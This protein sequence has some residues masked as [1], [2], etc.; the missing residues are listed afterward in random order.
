MS[1][2]LADLVDP[3]QLQS[4]AEAL[5]RISGIPIGIIGVDGRVLVA[6][7]WQ[8]VCANYHRVHPACL[9]RCLASDRYIVKTI[10]TLPPDGYIEYKC[11]NGMWDL[12]IPI[13]VDGHHLATC[14][15]GQFFY[16]HEPIDLA[17]FREQAGQHGF[18]P[19]A[20][21]AALEK[22]PVFSKEKVQGIIAYNRQLVSMIS[23]LG[24]SHL[25]Q[26]ERASRLETMHAQLLIE[27]GQRIAAEEARD[28]FFNLSPDLFAILSQ[29]G[30]LLNF[31]AALCEALG[32][33][34]EDLAEMPLD[35]RMHPEDREAALQ[36]IQRVFSGGEPGV[37]TLR[38][39]DRNGNPLWTEWTGVVDGQSLHVAGRD[40]TEQ[41]RQQESMA[42]EIEARKRAEADLLAARD[43]LRLQ[44]ACINRIQ[45]L[46]IGES[47]PDELFETLLFEILTLTASDYGFIVEVRRETS[48]EVNL[49]C[50]SVLTRDGE[51]VLRSGEGG[52]ASSWCVVGDH[53][54]FARLIDM[55]QPLFVNEVDASLALCGLPQGHP[56][57]RAMLGMPIKRGGEILAVLGLA[58]RPAGY[59]AGMIDYL[60]PVVAASAR[61][62]E[63]FG[64]RRRRLETETLLRK[65]EELLRATFESTRSGIL[66]V[67]RHGCILRTNARFREMWRIPADLLTDG[68]DDVLL[69][70]VLRQLKEPDRFL[71]RVKA[72]YETD[73]IDVDL[74]SFVDGR[75]FERYSEPL[76]GEGEPRG[77]VWIFTDITERMRAE[78]AVAENERRLREIASTLAEGL[79]T[80]GRDWR[81]TFINPTALRILGWREEEVLGHS[82]HLLFHHSYPDG[83]MYLASDCYIAQ[84]MKGT[85]V[86]TDTDWLWRK[87]GTCFPVALIASPIERDGVIQGAVVA[88]RD[89]TERK[90]ADEEL[91][92]AK[93]QA[94]QA[95]RVKGDF[96]AAMSHEIRTPMNVVLGMSEL[97]LETSLDVNQRRYAETMHY[98]GKALLGVLNDVLDFSRIEAGRFSLLDLPFSPVRV[99][100]ETARLMRVAAR[101]KG[102][103]L[104]ETI[105]VDLPEL[106]LGD[107]GRVRQV[108]LNLLSNAIKFTHQGRVDV[109]LSWYDQGQDALLFQVADTGIGISEEQARNVFEQFTQADAWITRRYGGTG[110]G[111]AICRRLVELMA[112]RIWV[113]SRL[114]EGSLFRFVLPVRRVMKRDA[115]ASGE[116]VSVAPVEERPLR[117]L[118]AEDVEENRELMAAYLAKTPHRLTMVEDGEEAVR[119]VRAEPFDVVVMDVQMPG[120]DGYTAT[121]LIRSWEAEQ[122]RSPLPVIALSAHAMEGEMER[123]R[124]A[125]C[126]LYLSKPIR[127]KVLIDALRGIGSRAGGQA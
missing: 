109:G 124:E 30:R 36:E 34:R 23:E 60:E 18:D 83:T 80:V 84:V 8:E 9:E 3:R 2:N 44:I 75:L 110:L 79:Y 33:S 49:T 54:L 29:D 61:I 20:Y 115:T 68:R 26:R 102:L 101:E 96:L 64:N 86:N 38:L 94:E 91:R 6:T 87:D 93:E 76:S 45:G 37:F 119:Q 11:L 99:V 122:G 88:F 48:G 47:D 103:V 92:L 95:A 81:I 98:S 21:L 39:I 104:G 52:V 120:M 118:L 57:I 66:V 27:I 113:E 56:P 82:S 106:V 74:L 14:F 32:Y 46:F 53:C 17:F 107:D 126:T 43:Q 121:R 15:L 55:A 123:S 5:Y 125:G 42:R 72:I 105:A 127:K 28:R 63:G 58:N 78:A 111:L 114:G 112:G 10:P 12:A 40:V 16:E 90:Q 117:I 22:V 1:I 50:L 35:A 41:H 62:L 25:R 31:N 51:G 13:L 69:P 24:L 77:R 4:M 65:S 89:I 116:M 85:V 71:A 7:G 59:D 97:L 100:E 67:D 19:D 70:F 73:A 108:L